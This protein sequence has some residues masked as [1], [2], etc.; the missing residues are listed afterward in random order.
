[1][2]ITNSPFDECPELS[3]IFGDLSRDVQLYF[4]QLRLARYLSQFVI[5][6]TTPEFYLTKNHSVDKI[7]TFRQE[8]EINNG[9]AIYNSNQNTLHNSEGREAHPSSVSWNTTF[10]R[11]DYIPSND[12]SQNNKL[13][14]HFYNTISR[15]TNVFDSTNQCQKSSVQVD[16][17]VMPLLSNREQFFS[18]VGHRNTVLRNNFEKA[19]HQDALRKHMETKKIAE[20][21]E[22]YAQQKNSTNISSPQS[23]NFKL[24]EQKINKLELALYMNQSLMEEKD[25][26]LECSK[27]VKKKCPT[28]H[29][30]PNGVKGTLTKVRASTPPPSLNMEKNRDQM[31]T[32]A[33]N[34]VGYNE[35]IYQKL[36]NYELKMQKAVE[37]LEK[38][39]SQYGSGPEHDVTKTPSKDESEP[40]RKPKED[41]IR[42]QT[43]SLR[44]FLAQK[45]HVER[46]R[47]DTL[48]MLSSDVSQLKK[49]HGAKTCRQG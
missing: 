41:I 4:F 2:S 38:R 7:N 12:M 45:A 8:E 29:R 27:I 1:M 10:N 35:S 33:A 18:S 40:I 22:L 43:A 28:K 3:W 16:R 19:N 31:T 49:F 17:N 5:Q 34:Y 36:K 37:S 11:G 48:D 9:N 47:K 13:G 14:E 26:E 21:N 23:T 15:R 44:S 6:E 20:E 39:V 46:F 30:V 25:M 24:L 42:K 32:P